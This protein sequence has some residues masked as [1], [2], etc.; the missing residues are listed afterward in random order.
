MRSPDANRTAALTSAA[1]VTRR[2]Q[3]SRDGNGPAAQPSTLAARRDETGTVAVAAVAAVAVAA[4]AVAAVAAVA[5]AVAAVAVA[6]PVAAAV[7]VAAVA[8]LTA[9]H[10]SGGDSG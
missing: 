7:A 8:E 5:V 4:V 3:R 6:A 10:I 9:V 2:R 1:G